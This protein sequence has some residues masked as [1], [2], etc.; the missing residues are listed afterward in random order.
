[1]DKRL[2]CIFIKEVICIFSK[3]TQE[4]IFSYLSKNNLVAMWFT[5]IRGIKMTKY[6]FK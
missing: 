5:T 1:M 2:I 6:D 3:L 4:N